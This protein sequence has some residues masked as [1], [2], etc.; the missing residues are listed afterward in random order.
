MQYK[1]TEVNIAFLKVNAMDRDAS[2][3]FNTTSLQ[4]RFSKIRKTQGFGENNG[5]RNKNITNIQC[6]NDDD[7]F[8]FNSLFKR[9]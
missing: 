9:G 3:H 4:R 5:D 1:P 8:D 2:L 6:V 7:W